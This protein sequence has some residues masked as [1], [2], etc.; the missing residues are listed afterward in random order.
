[1]ENQSRRIFCI[2]VFLAGFA[3]RATAID[4]QKAFNIPRELA[5]TSIRKFSDQTDINVLA[6][7]RSI[8]G[9]ITNEVIGNF[10]VSEAMVRLI[11][12]TGLSIRSGVNGTIMIG[13]TGAE[14]T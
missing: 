8:E 7:T 6:S 1:L 13:M 5:A 2:G 12:G 11:K 9:V 14:E 4:L 10:A 3:R